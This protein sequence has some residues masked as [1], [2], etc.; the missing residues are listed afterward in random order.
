[1]ITDPL[2]TVHEPDSTHTITLTIWQWDHI[3]TGLQMLRKEREQTYRRERHN[4]QLSANANSRKI[5]DALRATE[6]EINCEI[7]RQLNGRCGCED[8][9]KLLEAIISACSPPKEAA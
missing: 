2:E 3:V 5:I 4:C 7:E 8:C 6:K 1:M 9:Q